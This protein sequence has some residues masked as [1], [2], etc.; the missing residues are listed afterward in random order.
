MLQQRLHSECMNYVSLTCAHGEEKCKKSRVINPC[1]D[2]IVV[3]G[4]GEAMSSEIQ[5][6]VMEYRHWWW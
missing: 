3:K 2:V 4:G 6:P 1:R 5:N